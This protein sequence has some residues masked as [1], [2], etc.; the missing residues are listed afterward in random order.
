MDILVNNIMKNYPNG[1]IDLITAEKPKESEPQIILLFNAPLWFCKRYGIRQ[2]QDNKKSLLN[3]DI[4][5]K[6]PDIQTVIKEKVNRGETRLHFG[7]N[8]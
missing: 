8:K 3:L 2:P 4:I 1:V 5:K 7:E 6:P